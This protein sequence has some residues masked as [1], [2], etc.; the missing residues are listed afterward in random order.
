MSP[1]LIDIVTIGAGP[2][3]EARAAMGF[4][5]GGDTFVPIHYP[6]AR[7]SS[8]RRREHV[9]TPTWVPGPSSQNPV[10][11][12]LGPTSMAPLATI[13]IPAF[14]AQTTI[15]AAVASALAQTIAEVEVIV[16]DDGS[17]DRTADLVA[18]LATGDRRLVLVRH[19]G[20]R[21]PAAARNSA[22]ERARGAWFCCLEATDRMAPGRLASLLA[23]ADRWQVDLVADNLL[24]H[25]PVSG[26]VLG[27]A[28]GTERPIFRTAA[29]FVR[30][31]L[32]GGRRFRFSDLKP[33]VR[34]AVLGQHGVRFPSHLAVDE[35][36]HFWVECLLHGAELLLLPEAGYETSLGAASRRSDLPPAPILPAAG[37]SVLEAGPASP[38]PALRTNEALRGL[39]LSLGQGMAAE[40][41]KTRAGR[42]EV[43]H[44]YHCV[45]DLLR[46]RRLVSALAHLA[47][48]L[49]VLPTFAAPLAEGV[50]RRLRARKT[51]RPRA[52][53][54]VG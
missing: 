22:I 27:Y 43:L 28:P 7:P 10:L 36:F 30:N 39:A 38:Q 25:D 53:L 12:P 48:R 19:E 33:V 4:C 15:R 40:A 2:R 29:D 3:A 9:Q 32:P 1:R 18:E 24:Y 37:S 17:K 16:V 52:R 35:D 50:A 5:A 45:T 21:G 14:N 8:S 34:T 46:Q 51:S 20:R 26:E 49:D 31:D 42:I 23:A 11:Q 13:A 6:D 47:R 54:G 41:L 44:A